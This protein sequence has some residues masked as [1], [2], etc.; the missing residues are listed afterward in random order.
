[1]A[2]AVQVAVAN[3]VVAKIQDS[4]LEH[5][6]V[7]ER[8]YADWDLKLEGMDLLELRDIDKLRVDV[9]A[10]TTQQQ[11]GVSARGKARFI[12]PVDIA[13][14]RKFGKDKQKEDSGRIKVEEIDALVLLVQTL[15]V[16]FTQAVLEID[17]YDGAVW[18]SENGGTQ[19]LANPDQKQLREKRQFTGLVRLFFR[20]DVTL[21]A[22][23][24]D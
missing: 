21:N 12:V 2:D 20:V 23:S 18:D 10:H 3:A 24:A 4:E 11:S 16:M 5:D 22:K 13:V 8:S 1:M 6:F 17:G 14:R 7:P 19:V 15:C 9:V